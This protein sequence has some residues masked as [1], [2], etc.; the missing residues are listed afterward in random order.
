MFKFSKT[1]LDGTNGHTTH[2]KGH[3]IVYKVK[4]RRTRDWILGE[5][6]RQVKKQDF[7]VEILMNYSDYQLKVQ[8]HCVH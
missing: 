8:E 2:R 4:N 5:T 6:F 7:V 1:S 3:Y